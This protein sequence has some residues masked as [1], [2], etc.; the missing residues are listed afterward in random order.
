MSGGKKCIVLIGRFAKNDSARSENISSQ[1]LCSP[2]VSNRSNELHFNKVPSSIT[3]T[4][5]YN[6]R[7]STVQLSIAQNSSATL[8]LQYD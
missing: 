7:D 4:R 8:A 3:S 1:K 2:E 6:I 5:V